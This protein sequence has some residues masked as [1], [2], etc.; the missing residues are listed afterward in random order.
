VLWAAASGSNQSGGRAAF[1]RSG[2]FL[3]ELLIN[4]HRE[5]ALRLCK[6]GLQMA[7][8]PVRSYHMTHRSGWRDPLQDA[9]WERIFYA[10]HPIPEVALLT[11]L[12]SSLS[13]APLCPVE[14]CIHS[15][16]ELAAAAENYRD[17]VGLENV[18]QAHLRT[19]LAAPN[20]N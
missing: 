13:D 15:L 5:L 1:L 20:V 6:Q 3:T 16:E 14:A 10:A 12:W 19:R 8:T 18:R 9:A 2:G 17:V 7:G 4:G 11:F